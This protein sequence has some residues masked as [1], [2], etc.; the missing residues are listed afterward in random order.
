MN[1]RRT[2][3]PDYHRVVIVGGGFGGL[4]AAQSL[5][6]ARVDVI[7]LD[8]RNFHLFQPLLYQVATGGLSPANITAPLRDVLGRQRNARVLL[9]E[10]VDVDVQGCQVVLSDGDTMP[11]DTLIVAAGA[12]HHYFGNDEWREHAPGLKTIEDATAIR[13]R[14][15]FAF[16]AAEREKDPD[17]RRAWLNFVVVG[18]GPTGVELAGALGELANDTLKHEFRA[19]DPAEARVLLVE[20]AD[21]VL[22][23]YPP[24]LSARAARSLRRLGVTIQVQSFVTD[25]GP[26]SIAIRSPDESYRVPTRCV[27]WAAGVRASSL[28]RTIAHRTGADLDEAGRIHV[29]PDLSVHDHTE[30]LVIGDMARCPG[31]SGDPLPGVSPVAM[32]QGRYAAKLIRARLKGQD[33]PPFKY[34]HKGSLA[35]I[36]RSAAVADFGQLRFSGWLAWVLWLFVHVLFLIEFRNRI[37]VTLQWA[38]SYF[39]RNRGARLIVGRDGIDSRE[40]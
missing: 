39:T 37:L 13:R 8:R 27:L 11:Y 35:T 10:V 40:P 24:D 2:A 38:W 30:I 33:Y 19:I 23:G 25:V 7:L 4:Y 36:G 31:P 18:A 5:R 34:V 28:A 1:R 3:A 14:I 32:Q 17:R 21:R 9:G 16:E 20:G 26:D 29:N 6:R 22:P 12:S 15:L